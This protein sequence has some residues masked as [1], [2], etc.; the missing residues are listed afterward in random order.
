MQLPQTDDEI[1]LKQVFRSIKNALATFFLAI[2]K[3]CL[4]TA[5]HYKTFSATL[6]IGLI[7][8]YIVYLLLLWFK[9]IYTSKLILTSYRLTND[10]CHQ[11]ISTLEE[12]ADDE[13]NAPMLAKI[14]NL[15]E[16]EAEQIHDI[17]YGNLNEKI[18]KLYKDSVAMNLPFIVHVEV[19]DTAILDKLQ[20]GI[21]NY[22]ENNEFAAKRKILARQTLDSL[23]AE[24]HRNV[25]QLDSLKKTV[26]QSIIPRSSGT[27]IILG[28]PI[29]PVSI[30]DK[31]IEMYRSKLKIQEDI[32][33]LTNVEV[34]EG[35]VK[36]IKPEWPKLWLNLLLGGIGGYL[37]G[38]IWIFNFRKK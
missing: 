6:A 8:A 36:F 17:W 29:H 11:I 38:L 22:L 33:L 16:K 13:D 2:W 35:F 24:V 1:S 31:A 32:A 34:I 3:V 20:R 27:G 4:F 37:L 23:K 5:K 30:Y 26:E 7:V 18:E 21:V 9:P 10:I 19:Y 15:S 25:K 14:L 12:L 28:E